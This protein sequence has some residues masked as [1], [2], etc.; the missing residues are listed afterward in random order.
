MIIERKASNDNL[1]VDLCVLQMDTVRAGQLGH[2]D[3]KY[4]EN[5]SAEI[6]LR[7]AFDIETNERGCKGD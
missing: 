1:S 3:M 5:S 4:F 7:E 6:N 2:K